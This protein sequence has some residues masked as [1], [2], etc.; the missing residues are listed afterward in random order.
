MANFTMTIPDAVVDDV[1]NAFATAYPIPEDEGGTSLYTK[2][3]WAKMKLRDYVRSIYR[4]YK[5]NNAS[6]TARS[7]AAD[8]ADVDSK[9]VSVV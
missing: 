4:A 2:P 9:G 6:E 3:Q 8:A 5:A 7:I 1:L